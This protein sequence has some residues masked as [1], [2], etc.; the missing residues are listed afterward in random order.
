[1][2]SYGFVTKN[3]EICN[4]HGEQSLHKVDDYQQKV[5]KRQGQNQD[6]KNKHPWSIKAYNL[7]SHCVQKTTKDLRCQRPCS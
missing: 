6:R 7:N 1:M 2:K 5:S 4:H 3:L